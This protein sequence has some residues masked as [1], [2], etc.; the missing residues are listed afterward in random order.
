MITDTKTPRRLLLAGLVVFIL[1]LW[2]TAPAS[3][4]ETKAKQAILVD[5]TTGTVLFE[6]NADE[7]VPPSSMSKIMTIY[8]VFERLA[9]GRLKLDDTFLV[10]EKAWRKGGS[11]MFV[12]VGKEVSVE[13][14]IQGIIV[15]SGNDACIVVAEGLSGSEEAF[16]EEMTARAREIG[17]KASTFKNASGWPEEGHLVTVRDLAWLAHRTIQD[18]PQYYGY[19]SEKNFTYNGIKQGNRNPLLYRNTGSDGL[20]TGH[21][22]VAGYG[23][24]AS[25]V[26]NGRRLILVVNGLGSMRERAQESQRLLDWGFREFNNYTLLS[27]GAPVAEADVWLGDVPTVPLVTEK[28]LVLS[29]SR[30][31]RRGMKVTLVYEGPVPAPIPRGS[32]IAKLVITAPDTPPL[33]VPL[34]AGV[35]VGKLSMF[36]RIGAAIGYLVWGA[37]SN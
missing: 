20:K 15:A 26:R 11:K 1:A 34:L 24:T 3:A 31:A 18:F 37:G 33:E 6:K 14:L 25:A 35:D 10:S 4:I 32:E 8:M 9:E 13:N 2:V 28:D 23:L 36:R 19:Y 12:E 22:K 16:A 21:T 29:L 27:A 5:D 7:L 30:K 17:L